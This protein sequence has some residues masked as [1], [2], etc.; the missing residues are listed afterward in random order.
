MNTVKVIN[1][2]K[3]TGHLFIYL[4]NCSMKSLMTHILNP[5]KTHIINHSLQHKS[6]LHHFTGSDHTSNKHLAT[7][8]IMTPR[9]GTSQ[10]PKIL[11]QLL[12]KNVHLQSLEYE[13]TYID[14]GLKISF[15]FYVQ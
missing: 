3:N 5:Q 2:H 15:N 8:A 4:F 11:L 9:C 13:P 1:M 10:R 6:Y 12:V 7:V 14:F